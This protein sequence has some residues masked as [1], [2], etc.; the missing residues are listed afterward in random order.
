MKDLVS[1]YV[2]AFVECMGG[3]GIIFIMTK[4]AKALIDLIG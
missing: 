2:M 3:I 4:F 1:E